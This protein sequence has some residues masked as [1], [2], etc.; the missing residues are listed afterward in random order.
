MQPHDPVQFACLI[1]RLRA[2]GTFTDDTVAALAEAMHLRTEDLTELIDHAETLSKAV[3]ARID[4]LTSAKVYR[5]HAPTICSCREW[6]APSTAP[7]QQRSQTPARPTARQPPTSSLLKPVAISINDTALADCLRNPAWL[8]SV[9]TTARGWNLRWRR[10]T[11]RI[12]DELV[13]HGGVFAANLPSDLP[14]TVRYDDLTDPAGLQVWAQTGP[15]DALWGVRLAT[16]EYERGLHYAADTATQVEAVTA[17]LTDLVRRL[18]DDLRAVRSVLTSQ[19]TPSAASDTE[20]RQLIELVVFRDPDAGTAVDLYID[21]RHH[22]Q[23]VEYHIDPGR[24]TSD[25][26][27]EQRA[28]REITLAGASPAA[29]A[30]LRGLYDR[31]PIEE[32]D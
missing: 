15:D 4:S 3:S 14:V 18:N 24:G 20:T 16:V 6:A 13:A 27:A 11:R 5:G 17:F 26:T 30:R 32:T 23:V 21:G 19:T 31:Y 25:D 9:P 22:K 7:T 8:R 28:A 12:I 2:T 10:E 29:A 1:A